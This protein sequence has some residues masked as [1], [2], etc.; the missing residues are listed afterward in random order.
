[1]IC[2]HGVKT[3]QL[4]FEFRILLEMCGA[5]NIPQSTLNFVWND[6]M[7]KFEYGKAI[8]IRKISIKR[9]HDYLK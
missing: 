1:M 5:D 2:F 6:F 3:N 9:F 8:R 4:V 7:Y